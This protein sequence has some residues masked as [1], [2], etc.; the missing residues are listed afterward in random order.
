MITVL[1]N[2]LGSSSVDYSKGIVQYQTMSQS[3]ILQHDVQHKIWKSRQETGRRIQKNVT[4][5]ISPCNEISNSSILKRKIQIGAQLLDCPQ[6]VNI[7]VC[8]RTFLQQLGGDPKLLGPMKQNRET[9][10]QYEMRQKCC[11][12]FFTFFSIATYTQDYSKGLRL[13]MASLSKK[14]FKVQVT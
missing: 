14:F 5:W 8:D 7:G 11:Q 12:E 13:D 3:I 9:I 4:S 6:T 1:L 10:G 2:Y